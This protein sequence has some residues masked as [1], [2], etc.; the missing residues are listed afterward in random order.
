MRYIEY[1][2]PLTFDGR[3]SYT[4]GLSFF[5]TKRYFFGLFYW[6]MFDKG[7]TPI[8][9]CFIIRKSNGMPLRG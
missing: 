4:R 8:D 2:H 6:V 7:N 9:K 1:S 3:A 5:E